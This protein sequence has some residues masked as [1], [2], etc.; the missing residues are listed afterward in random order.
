MDVDSVD[1]RLQ[2]A[3]PFAVQALA[4][5]RARAGS[6]GRTVAADIGVFGSKI[7]RVRRDR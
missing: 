2:L 6:A 3:V 7:E 1:V 5:E 4:R